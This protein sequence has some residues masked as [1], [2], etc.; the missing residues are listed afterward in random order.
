MLRCGFDCGVQLLC[1]I[2][3]IQARYRC[4]CPTDLR[5]PVDSKP[6][7]YSLDRR[8]VATLNRSR[9]SLRS[10]A[11]SKGLAGPLAFPSAHISLSRRISSRRC[12]CLNCQSRRASRTISLVVAYSPVSTAA[13]RAVSC[14]PV[15]ATLTFWI[16]GISPL[17]RKYYYSL[18]VFDP[19]T[20]DSLQ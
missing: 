7:Q 9:A 13:F 17:S 10:F 18:L 5:E 19:A 14:S 16:S 8:F 15:N 2:G 12:S 6:V 11:K 3:V 4:K 1:G 20:H